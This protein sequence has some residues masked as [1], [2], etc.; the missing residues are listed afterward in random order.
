MQK[1][2]FEVNS[3]DKK[4]YEKFN[5]TEDILM[6]NASQAIAKFIREEKRLKYKKS[7]LIV[8]G[9]GNN[10]ADGITLARIL[11]S[12]YMVCLYLPLGAKSNMAKLQLNRA[13]LVGVEVVESIYKCDIVIDCLF[14][15]GLNKPLSDEL[16]TLID[17]LNGL[18]SYKIAC[19]IPSGIDIDGDIKGSAF[20]A[21]TTITMG[22][23][24]LSLFS[25]R[26]KDFVGEIKVANLG[27]ARDI[28]EDKT[29]YYLLQESDLK[30]PIRKQKS[31]HKGSYGHLAV[32]SGDKIGAS[33]ISG[34][35]SLSFGAGLVTLITKSEKQIPYE[36]M[37]SDNLASTTS[38]IAIGMGLGEAFSSDEIKSFLLE[39]KLATIIDADLF[40]KKLI[41]KLLNKR[42]DLILTP[43]PKEFI[44]LLKFSDI[45]DID[46]Q[47]LQSNRFKYTLEFSKKY[48]NVVLLLKGANSIIAYNEKLYINPLGTEALA[49]GGSGDVLA[50]LIGALLAQGYSLLDSAIHASLAHSLASKSFDK[51][52]YS[53]TPM[54][55]IEEIK[56]LR[57]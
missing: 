15:S 55:L 44:S 47:T 31:T 28:Y 17:E 25:D 7:I 33:V 2:F 10:G 29:N 46:T 41:V 19:D 30:L 24:K 45:A 21:N 49:K 32:I 54:D 4:C 6:E 34:L 35:S 16:N 5:L 50:G 23:L 12:E 18:N 38:A 37:Q 57:V 27:V 52:N 53:L 26:A 22:A 48:P 8:A 20:I 56:K 42:D 9:A 13:K 39:Q 14:G 36:L 43:H 3:L 51:N 1:L 11:H 40:H